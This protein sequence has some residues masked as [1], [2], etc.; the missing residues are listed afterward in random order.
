MKTTVTFAYWDKSKSPFKKTQKTITGEILKETPK[1]IVIEEELTL[2]QF[3]IPKS[4]IS[5]ITD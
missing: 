5:F 4:K 3:T 2:S 1:Q